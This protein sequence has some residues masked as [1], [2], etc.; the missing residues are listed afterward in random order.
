MKFIN[1]EATTYK[2]ECGRYKSIIKD[3]ENLQTAS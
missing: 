3:M 2:L 1:W